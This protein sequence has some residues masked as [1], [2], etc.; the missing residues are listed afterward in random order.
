MCKLC[1]VNSSSVNIRGLRDKSKRLKVFNWVKE[2]KSDITLFQE[3]FSLEENENEWTRDWEGGQVIFSHGTNHS[4]GCLITVNK[5]LDLKILKKEVD[6]NGRYILLQVEL[7]GEEFYIFNIYLPNSVHE[8]VNYLEKLK[9]IMNTYDINQN[10]NIIMGGDWNIIQSLTD[11][12]SINRNI[13]DTSSVTLT[14]L[15]TQFDLCDIWRVRNPTVKSFTY[16]KVKSSY[17]SRLGFWLIS[18]ILQEFIVYSDILPN[19]YSDHSAIV[20]GYQMTQDRD[21]GKGF[22]KFNSSLLGEQTYVESL[23][24]SIDKWLK[25]YKEVQSKQLIWE[26]LKYEIRKFTIKYSKEKKSKCAT[27]EKELR[28]RTKKQIIRKIVRSTK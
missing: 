28:K 21:K 25:E 9:N 22:W 15:M 2:I 3:T 17:R 6:V 18:D 23:N 12:Q 24:K 20:V 16:R 19:I 27:Q 1:P 26:L 4:R 10:S 5:N 11:K 7:K 14:K 13:E 8:R